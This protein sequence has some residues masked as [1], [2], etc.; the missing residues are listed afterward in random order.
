MKGIISRLDNDRPAVLIFAG[1]TEGRLLAEHAENCRIPCFVSTATEY[2]KSLVPD[3]AYVRCIAGRMDREEILHFMKEHKISL[4][5]D[6]THP[7]AREVTEN[8]KAACE[9]GGVPYVRCLRGE[10]NDGECSGDRQ[11]EGAQ[12]I[13]VQS[14][15]DAVEYLKGT[16]GNILIT[17]GSRELKRYTEITDYKE[18]CFARVLST[19]ETVEAAVELGFEGKHLIAMQGPFSLEMNQALLHQTGAKYFVTKESGRAGGFGEKAEAAKKAGAVL[20]VIGRPEEEGEDLEVVM[21]MM[22]PDPAY[23]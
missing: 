17:T 4:T 13:T 2:G 23:I 14:V 1:T 7:F 10:E 8:I 5:I 21:Q 9:K 15:E 20:V 22:K 18:R 6:A 19:R 16:E 12:I 11:P 3:S